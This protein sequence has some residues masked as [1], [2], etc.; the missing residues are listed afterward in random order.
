MGFIQYF[1]RPRSRPEA[2]FIISNHATQISSNK[3]RFNLRITCSIALD[4]ESIPHGTNV[5][6]SGSYLPV[7]LLAT[8]TSLLGRLTFKRILDINE[9]QDL[10]K[11][12]SIF[13]PMYLSLILHKI[14]R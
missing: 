5:N 1:Y 11:L 10:H 6:K 13:L 9:I 12:N 8:P 7:L 14:S 2:T 4:N 3:F